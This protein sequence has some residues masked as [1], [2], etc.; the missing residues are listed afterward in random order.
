[1]DQIAQPV[2]SEPPPQTDRQTSEDSFQSLV[3]RGLLGEQYKKETAAADPVGTPEA[4]Q[5]DPAPAAAAEPEAPEYESF[6][7][8]AG[9]NKFEPESLYSLPVTVKIDGKSSLV[10]LKDVLKSYQLEGHVQE[11]SRALAEQRQAWESERTAA[12]QALG[13]QLSQA[14]TLGNLAHQQLLAEYQGIN[15]NQLRAENP[16]EWAVRNQEFQNRANGIAAHLNQVQQHQAQLAAQQQQELT[17][18]VIPAEQERMYEAR[19]EWRDSTKFQAD[20]AAMKQYASKLGFK[21]AELAGIYDHR[22]MIALHD[23]ARY[24]AL[25]AASPEALKRVRSAPQAV[26]PGSRQQRD[27]QAVAHQQA[28]ERLARNPRDSEAAADV[29]QRYASM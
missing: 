3:D 15:W 20:T 4:H 26:A 29:F 27:P 2:A 16:A 9:K 22:I 5:A 11:K 28:R 8:F 25:Q 14:Q 19:P 6:E 10:P 23:A 12:Q 17:S 1:M 13:A 24:A 21:P 18:K 7:D